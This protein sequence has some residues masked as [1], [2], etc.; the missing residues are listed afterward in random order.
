MSHEIRTPMNGIIGMTELA[1]DTPLNAEQRE[2]LTA[3]RRLGGRAADGH[4]RHP[5]LLEDR[6]GQAR[7]RIR[8]RSSCATDRRTRARRL[9]WPPRTKGLELL[10]DIAPDVPDQRRGR[11]RAAAPDPGQPGRQR[12]QV[13]RAWRGGAVGAVSTPSPTTRSTL[14]FAVRDTGIG[15]PPDKQRLIFR[16]SPRPIARPRGSTAA[17]G[18]GWRSARSWSR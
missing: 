10:C 18:W 13:H 6:G 16:P 9:A 14:H 12:H 7:A 11:S 4:Q 8:S 1:L 5:R 2:Y 15:I 17:P 3:V